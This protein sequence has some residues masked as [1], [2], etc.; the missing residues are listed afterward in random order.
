MIDTRDLRSM[1]RETAELALQLAAL[2]ADGLRNDTQALNE[3]ELLAGRIMR[4]A[5]TVR[6]GATQTAGETR[7]MWRVMQPVRP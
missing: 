6:A 1:A 2:P 3:I 4:E 7:G 5:S